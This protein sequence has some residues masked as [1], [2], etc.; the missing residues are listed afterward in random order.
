MALQGGDRKQVVSPCL[1]STPYTILKISGLDSWRALVFSEIKAANLPNQSFLS[2]FPPLSAYMCPA[3]P[4]SS[5]LQALISP[6]HSPKHS[7]QSLRSS[8]RCN[9]GEV[10]PVLPVGAHSWAHSASGARLRHLLSKSSGS[11]QT[12]DPDSDWNPFLGF[13]GSRKGS[14]GPPDSSYQRV[15]L[16][17]ASEDRSRGQCF[18]V[19]KFGEQQNSVQRALLY[20]KLRQD[21]CS[22]AKSIVFTK[23]RR[24]MFDSTQMYDGPSCHRTIRIGDNRAKGPNWKGWQLHAPKVEVGR[25]F[26]P[27]E[28]GTDLREYEAIAREFERM[29]DKQE[30]ERKG[31]DFY[32]GDENREKYFE[33]LRR[34]WRRRKGRERPKASPPKE[35]PGTVSEV[36]SVVVE[37]KVENE[38]EKEEPKPRSRTLPFSLPFFPALSSPASVPPS[39]KPLP[40]SKPSLQAS[41][42]PIVKVHRNHS[43]SLVIRHIHPDRPDTPKYIRKAERQ[44]THEMK[45]RNETNVS[46]VDVEKRRKTCVSYNDLI[47]RIKGRSSLE[48]LK[49]RAEHMTGP[50]IAK[51]QL[52]VGV[53]RLYLSSFAQSHS[54]D[55]HRPSILKKTF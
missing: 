46:E 51:E 17:L 38:T 40:A 19:D 22:K 28:S 47:A 53:A 5:V 14:K 23:K 48:A 7:N 37:E 18:K 25:R 50:E 32:A 21:G 33:E 15:E 2:K 30:K 12:A 8:F 27:V 13:I 45:K 34:E 29:T 26:Q 35:E 52:I 54:P 44:K 3:S 43:C 9:S 4:K 20:L 10:S 1:S 11:L 49:T 16:F 39:P 6:A 36:P 31:V 24:C 55:S 42:I 41:E